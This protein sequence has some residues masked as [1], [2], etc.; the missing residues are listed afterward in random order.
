M[1]LVDLN[2]LN[3]DSNK[4]QQEM[5]GSNILFHRDRLGDGTFDDAVLNLG[6]TSLRYP[7]GSITEEVFDVNNPNATEAYDNSTKE[8]R[9]LLPLDEFL[10]FCKTHEI[11]ASI[12]IP[13]RPGILRFD[14]NS[15][16]VDETFVED[17]KTF[18]RDVMSGRYGDAEIATFEIG[19]EYWGSGQMT[20]VEYSS[21]ADKIAVSIQQIFNSIA[22]TSGF[23]HPEPNIAVQFGKYGKYDRSD[24]NEQNQQIIKGLSD[25]G[26]EAIDEVIAHLYHRNDYEAISTDN[27]VFDRLRQW[28][29]VDGM[30]DIEFRISE[31]NINSKSGNEFGLKQASS[32]LEIM[33]KMS[34]EG[35]DAA[36][37]WPI[38]QNNR[39]K[40]AGDEGDQYYSPAGEMFKM[41]SKS[42][43]GKSV[44]NLRDNDPNLF[45]NSFA[46]SNSVSLF[47]HSRSDEGF[48]GKVQV[49]ELL[50]LLPNGQVYLKVARLTSDGS[51]SDPEAKGV[52]NEVGFV[53]AQNMII[54]GQ[55]AISA[56]PFEIVHIEIIHLD[57]HTQ[58]FLS[59]LLPSIEAGTD[60]NIA[61]R[62]LTI[63]TESSDIVHVTEVNHVSETEDSDDFVFSQFIG[64][65]DANNELAQLDV[66]N[67]PDL[68]W[69][70]EEV[71]SDNY[72]TQDY[73]SS[74]QLLDEV[75]L[76]HNDDTIT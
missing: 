55:L 62:K 19:N 66:N 24:A 50:D 44:V 40:L 74:E 37:I 72:S 38:Q 56:T 21:I 68:E 28:T 52:V 47:V 70:R 30:D 5:F 35:I 51:P 58:Q 33:S 14:D 61:L 26:L 36:E 63:E 32:I 13:V 3:I 39:T 8:T 31:W 76:I 1:K 49:K 73:T 67:N 2:V 59:V 10:A 29:D 16:M 64:H 18:V 12:V 4:I 27:W 57:K 45:L 23:S 69:G 9:T 42:L 53:D 6:V 20:A 46:D 25:E 22:E 65:Y 15:Y 11:K 41:M 48:N 54:N 43:S 60:F 17:I 75:T 7:G 34:I 71:N